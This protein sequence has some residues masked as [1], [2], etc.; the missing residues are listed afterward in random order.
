VG[1]RIGIWAAQVVLA[2][3]FGIAGVLKTTMA[4]T[5]LH[6]MGIAWA[7]DVPF[8]LLR[9]IG[10][11][12]LLGAIGVVL[13]ALTRILP[14]LTPLAAAGFAVIQVLAIGYHATRGETAATL[15]LNILL[16]VLSLFVIWGRTRK[17]P[18]RAR[19]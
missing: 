11:A 15:P 13:P 12:E 19:G 1:W 18:I 4:P 10:T 17:A 9:F 14:S 5:A 7:T 2:V 6:Q 16:L 3:L 8:A